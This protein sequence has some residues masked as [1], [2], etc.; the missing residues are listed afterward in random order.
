MSDEQSGKSQARRS[1]PGKVALLGAGATALAV[2]NMSIGSEAE[3]QAVLILQYAALG[4]G[5]LALVGGLIMM[6]AQR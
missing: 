6:F 5:L 2:L 3:P 1:T 4:G